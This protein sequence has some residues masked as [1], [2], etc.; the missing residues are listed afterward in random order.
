MKEEPFMDIATS[1]EHNDPFYGLTIASEQLQK[2]NHVLDAL[3]SMMIA[4]SW[5]SAI[6][7]LKEHMEKTNWVYLYPCSDT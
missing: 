5:V 2:A 6:A 7:L 3:C 1:K 4:S